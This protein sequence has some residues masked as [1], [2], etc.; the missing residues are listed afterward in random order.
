MTGLSY[1]SPRDFV[2]LRRL[3]WSVAAKLAREER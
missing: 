2:Y 3:A 1:R